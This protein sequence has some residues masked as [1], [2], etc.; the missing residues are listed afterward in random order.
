MTLISVGH[1]QDVTGT[2]SD[3]SKKGTVVPLSSSSRS[4]AAHPEGA[5][6]TEQEEAKEGDLSRKDKVSL[7][8]EYLNFEWNILSSLF[9]LF[10]RNIVIPSN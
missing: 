3:P 7:V 9:F 2:V 6:T 8:L 5:S 4:D 1:L 10:S